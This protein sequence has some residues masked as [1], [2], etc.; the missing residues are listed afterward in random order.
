VAVLDGPVVVTAL[1]YL[2]AGL[3]AAV[4]VLALLAGRA[5]RGWAAPG[6]RHEREPATTDGGD[7]DAPD[8]ADLDR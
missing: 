6:T 8:R 5:A 3:G 4:V 7:W 1:P 2:A